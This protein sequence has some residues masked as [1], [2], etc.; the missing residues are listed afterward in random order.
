MW[1]TGCFACGAL[2][3]LIFGIPP[4]VDVKPMVSNTQ[5][6][7]LRKAQ[8]DLESAKKADA[9]AQE[10]LTAAVKARDAGP[11]RN[12]TA[13]QADLDIGVK[14]AEQSAVSTKTKVATAQAALDS[15]Q[16]GSGK[17]TEGDDTQSKRPTYGVNTNLSD[18][19]DWLTKIIVG[20]GLVQ[21]GKIRGQLKDAANFVAG[22]LVGNSSK[23]ASTF[24]PIALGI[25]LYFSVL[26]FLSSYL[27]TRVWLSLL[28]NTFAKLNV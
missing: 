11:Q 8:T 14:N 3:G 5:D 6:A 16:K 28:L 7:P 22:G 18:I 13:T 24:A 21:L 10:T 17:E 9:T 23:A 19:S 27:L 26:G 20:V 4:Y 15:L 2:L 1:G 25:I 12:S